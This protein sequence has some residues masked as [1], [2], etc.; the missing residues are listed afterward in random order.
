MEK[1]QQRKRG[2]TTPSFKLKLINENSN[3]KTNISPTKF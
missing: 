1:Q 3:I 2:G